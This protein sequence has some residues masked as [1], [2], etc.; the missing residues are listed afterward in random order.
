MAAGCLRDR[1][2]PI[3]PNTTNPVSSVSCAQL[4]AST[5]RKFVALGFC[6]GRSIVSAVG[7]SFALN[8]NQHATDKAHVS[9]FSHR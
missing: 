4:G 1:S 3:L 6:V 2:S 9:L 7:F 5:Y 8:G